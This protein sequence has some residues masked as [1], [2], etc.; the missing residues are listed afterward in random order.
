[1]KYVEA[2]GAGF[3]A[4]AALLKYISENDS[5]LDDVLKR[6]PAECQ[7]ARGVVA[8][9]QKYKGQE[10]V[11]ILCVSQLNLQYDFWPR[12]QGGKDDGCFEVRSEVV[13]GYR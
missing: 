8:A 9:M 7:W 12:P 6:T 3:Q 13:L 10:V 4:S 2:G 11:L 5:G 1:V